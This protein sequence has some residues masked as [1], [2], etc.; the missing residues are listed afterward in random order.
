[1]EFKTK[2]PVIVLDPGHG[3]DG[4]N[5]GAQSRKYKYKLKGS[6]GKVKLDKNKKEITDLKDIMSLPQYVIDNP[7]KW[8]VGDNESSNHKYD[9][10]R[11]EYGLTYDVASK[12]KSILKEKGYENTL[13]TRTSK[14]ITK[15]TGHKL[16]YRIDIANNKKADYF[17][18][19]HAD[20]SKNFTSGSHAIYSNTDSID[21]SKKISNDI[22]KYYNVVEVES[23]SPKKDVRGL[24]VL[25]TTNKT[26]RKTLVELG[27]L[28]SPS[29]AKKMF[30]NISLMAEQLTKGLIENIEANF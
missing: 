1:M 11:T 23:D 3:V 24:R 5:V 19:I 18:S 13:L 10:D 6:D 21:E 12:M 2:S 4:G 29:D 25:R 22:M 15:V 26:K 14:D 9:N 27:F 20:G 8:I 17:I 16:A 28:T 30:S 7:S